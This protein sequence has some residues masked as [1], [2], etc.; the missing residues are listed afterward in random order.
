MGDAGTFLAALAHAAGCLA[1][2]QADAALIVAA[3]ESDWL[4]ADASR[5][6][7]RGTVVSE[8]AGALYLRSIP[9]GP[10][11]PRL[12]SITDAHSFLSDRG[13]SAAVANMRAQ[14]PVGTDEDL[15]VDSREC[16]AAF[17]APEMKA[18][19]KWPGA[20]L[21]PK[22]VLGDG[23]AAGGAWQCV[24]AAAS[25]RAGRHRRVLVSVASGNQQAIGAVLEAQGEDL[26]HGRLD[27]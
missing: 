8:G 10:E 6:F 24:L 20:G 3:E 25:I 19:A 27:S 18:W 23:L 13:R 26:L 2:A 7:R 11:S 16:I 21:S 5:R 12:V 15:L 17:D 9:A 14:L 1:E 4:V 22:R